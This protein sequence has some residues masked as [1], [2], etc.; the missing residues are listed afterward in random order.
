[1]ARAE[2][3]QEGLAAGREEAR[4][5]AGRQ[6]EGA[7]QLLRDALLQVQ[8]SQAAWM[9]TLEQNLVVLSLAAARHIV[10]GEVRQDP[11]VVAALVKQ[12]ISAFP[13]DHRLRIRLSPEDLSAL[14]AEGPVG[15]PLLPSARELEWVAD[16]TIGRGGCM[17][18]GP[19]SVLDGRVDNA[20]ERLYWS[21]VE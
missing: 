5:E 17:V 2:G 16:A 8:E 3:F 15:R 14:S 4:R 19:V 20:L 12:A 18:E 6:V 7:L 13:Q 10:E 1:V 9:E 11:G 21:I